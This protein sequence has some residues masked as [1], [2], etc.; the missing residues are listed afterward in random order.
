MEQ[1]DLRQLIERL[2]QLHIQRERISA[3][4]RRIL[5]EIHQPFIGDNNNT[6]RPT[7]RA[8]VEDDNAVVETVTVVPTQDF[9][10]GQHVYITNTITHT[11]L[12]RRATHADRAAI[13]T[14]FT[15]TG[16]IGLRTYNGYRTHRLSGNLRPLTP[17]E[18]TLFASERRH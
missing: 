3:E 10:L 6:E 2:Q 13:V 17:E 18:Q 14:H 5:Q 7:Q 4:E 12:V 15:N 9:Q 8:V 1:E 16:R 11:G